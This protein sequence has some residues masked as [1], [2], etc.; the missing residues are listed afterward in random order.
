MPT[1]VP[2]VIPTGAAS[3][4][5]PP[6]ARGA[7]L[8]AVAA[9]GFAIMNAC[10]K[11]AS[12]RVPFLEVAFARSLVGALCVAAWA[13]FRG[14]SLAVQNRKVMMLRA[15]SGTVAMSLTFY[16]IS[17]APLGEASA[18]LNLTPLFV[19]GIGV[20]WLRERIAPLVGICLALSLLL[21][22][23]ITV[24]FVVGVGTWVACAAPVASATA[25]SNRSMN[26]PI[27]EI[28]LLSIH[29]RT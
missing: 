7:V 16:A 1:V 5:A 29:S 8:M 21:A 3:R 2:T 19:A 14:R 20:M 27:E 15:A 4:G 28:Q 24:T 12:R 22:F 13:R 11:E 18:L 9:I 26:A 25:C 23:A 17:K 10:A 6:W